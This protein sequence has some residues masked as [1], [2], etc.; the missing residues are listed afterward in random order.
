M[1]RA[2][3]GFHLDRFQEW[4]ADLECGHG[5]T[6]KH[7]PP[8]Q[9]CSW[10]G[11][12]MKRKEHVGDVQE[13]VTCDMPE[14][15]DNLHLAE[16]SPLYDRDTMPEQ[17]G[18]GYIVEGGLWAKLVVKKGLLQFLVY[19]DPTVGFVLDEHLYGVM[20]PGVVHE[21]KPAMGDVEFYLE[22]YQA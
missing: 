14:L 12:A 7:N 21:I 16:K 20:A 13:C 15:P 18:L 8:Y 1:K 4:V 6:M 10:I 5:L 9:N 22:F 17:F 3:T 19:S 11:S 2:I